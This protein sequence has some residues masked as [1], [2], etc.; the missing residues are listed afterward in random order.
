MLYFPSTQ[1][2]WTAV[3]RAAYPKMSAAQAEALAARL[4]TRHPGRPDVQVMDGEIQ[5]CDGG[6]ATVAD[7]WERLTA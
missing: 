4:K 5:V 7:G 2:E 3:V 6:G 1:S